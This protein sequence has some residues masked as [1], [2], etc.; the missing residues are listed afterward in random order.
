MDQSLESMP[1][2]PISKVLDL[3][4]APILLVQAPP[5][6][7]PSSLLAIVDPLGDV[8][9]GIDRLSLEGNEEPPQLVE[10]L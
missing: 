1:L 5:P 8:I 2:V 10:Q 6:Q 3:A 9:E 7:D 4:V